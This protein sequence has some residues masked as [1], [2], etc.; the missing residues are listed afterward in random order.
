MPRRPCR[1]HCW[2]TARGT[3]R[4]GRPPCSAPPCG[5][6]RRQRAQQL[7]PRLPRWQPR[8]AVRD[9]QARWPPQCL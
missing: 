4:S 5:R 6:R 7:R 3:Q 8:R 1:R 2:P 9:P